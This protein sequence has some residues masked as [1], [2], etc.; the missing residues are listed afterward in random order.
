M[1]PR[2]TK[3]T[4]TEQEKAPRCSEGLDFIDFI[5][6][7]LDFWCGGGDLNPYALRR[8]HLKLVR[9]PIS[10]PPHG[11][12]LTSIANDSVCGRGGRQCLESA[13]Q[14]VWECAFFLDF[15]VKSAA[16]KIP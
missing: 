7:L 14:Q 4:K 13:R 16:Q 3:E 12:N 15:Q 8:Q 6:F 1:S 2:E 5:T 9:L 11:V 10:P